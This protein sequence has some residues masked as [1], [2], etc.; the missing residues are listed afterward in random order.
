MVFI[1]IEVINTY[2]QGNNESDNLLSQQSDMSS[3]KELQA[4]LKKALEP[5]DVEYT[6]YPLSNGSQEWFIRVPADLPLPSIHLAVKKNLDKAGI[7]ILSGESKPL[8][9]KISLKIGCGDLCLMKVHLIHKKEKS[10]QGGLIA[11]IIDDFGSRW[12]SSIEN[13]LKIGAEFTCSVIPGKKFSSEIAY[14]IK[15][16]GHEVLLH[17]PME[18]ENPVFRSE[19]VIILSDMSPYQIRRI[20]QKA[21]DDIPDAVGVNNHMGSKITA[22]QKIMRIILNM[23]K[24][25]NMFFVDS[26]TT[27]KSIAYDVAKELGVAA[28][29]RD[30]FIDTERDEK[31]IRDRL[32]ELARCADRKGFAIGI[33]HCSKITLKVLQDEVPRIQKKGYKFVNVSRVVR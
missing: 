13:F 14:R 29:K 32:W 19:K 12:D 26:R 6:F 24:A 31:I 2:F 18:P 28:G 30:V 25:E 15:Q 11:L 27:S 3:I 5:F 33:G 9:D 16:R 1:S 7:D 10:W 8:L 17:L 4:I 20:V 23:L 21:F 22:D